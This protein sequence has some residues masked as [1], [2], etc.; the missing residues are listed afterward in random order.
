M[1]LSKGPPVIFRHATAPH[2]SQSMVMLL[3]SEVDVEMVM[4]ANKKR[5]GFDFI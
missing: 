5:R 3:G 4:R 1:N 2:C